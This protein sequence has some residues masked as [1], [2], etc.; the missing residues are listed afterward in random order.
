MPRWSERWTI[1]L[2]RQ[3]AITKTIAIRFNLFPTAESWNFG[4]IRDYGI[5]I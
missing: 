3:A 1:N 2:K 4:H 5:L